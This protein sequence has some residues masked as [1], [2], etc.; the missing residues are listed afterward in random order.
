MSSIVAIASSALHRRVE[1]YRRAGQAWA[2]ARIA[3]FALH[4]G[5]FERSVEAEAQLRAA[6]S[7]LSR[8]DQE[9]LRQA[10]VEGARQGYFEFAPCQVW[11]LDR[12]PEQD[13]ALFDLIRDL[14]AYPDGT[15]LLVDDSRL[16][17]S[18]RALLREAGASLHN[19]LRFTYYGFESEVPYACWCGWPSRC[20]GLTLPE[21][22]LKNES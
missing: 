5:S 13:E 20:V 15:A 21:R 3:Y 14:R 9:A 11:R 10:F 17:E 16:K 22:G 18:D 8:A 6:R 19:G 2:Q 1:M 7:C 4:G 12:Q